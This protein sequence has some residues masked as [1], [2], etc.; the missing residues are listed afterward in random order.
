MST[1]RQ[2][3][4]NTLIQIVG[5]AISTFLGLIALG[6]MTRY[7]GQEQFGWYITVISFLGFVGIMID[8]GLIPVTAQMMS[9]PDFDKK[10]LFKNL[11]GFRFVTALFFLTTIP[12]IALFFPYPREVKLAI[13][14]TTVSFFAIAMNQVLIGF[15]QTKLKM[16]FQIVG[17]NLGRLILVFGLW[18]F[19]GQQASFLTLMWVVVASSVVYTAFLWICANRE[20]PAGLAF[21]WP[22]WKTIMAKMWPITVSIIFNVVY[23]KGDIILLSLFRDQAEVG[24]YGAAYRVIEILTQLAMMLMGVMLPL[25]AYHWS[26][27]LKLGFRKYYQQSFDAMMAIA[28]PMA[29]GVIMLAEKIIVLVAGPEFAASGNALRILAIAVFGLYLGAVFGHTAV[30]IN[31]QKQTMWIY[32]STAIITLIGYFIFIPKYGMYG[33]AW[34]TVFSELYVG[35]LLFFT[36]RHFSQ[37]KLQIKTLAKIIFSGVVMAAVLFLLKELHVLFLIIIGGAVYLALLLALGG[38]SK[39][40]IKEITALKSKE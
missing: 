21:D 9:E 34:M 23:L 19:I 14:F 11:L 26:R 32:I 16:I 20:S 18:L 7:L 27:N 1:T 17:E 36:I 10:Q 5:K 38:I 3:A 35:I 13:S 15:Y 2:I 37:E 40:T 29:L 12:L 8:F 4:H 22:I 28:V 25:L 31:R 39:E 24:I 6:M 30:A 33:A